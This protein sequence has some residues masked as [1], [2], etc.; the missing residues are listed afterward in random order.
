ML[1]TQETAAKEALYFNEFN[2]LT[3]G[4]LN[5]GEVLDRMLDYVRNVPELAYQISIGTDSSVLGDHEADFV[6]AIVVHSQNRGGIYFWSKLHKTG[7]YRKGFRSLHDRMWEETQFSIQLAQQ[8][9]AELKNRELNGFKLAIHVDLGPNGETKVLIQE[10]VGIVRAYG[11]D[12]VTK[13]DSYAASSVADR[14][15]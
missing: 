5:F 11:Y 12:V 6:S 4:R 14:H 3:Y 2:S 13:P 8:L 15:T 1:Q 9:F 10:M 7:F